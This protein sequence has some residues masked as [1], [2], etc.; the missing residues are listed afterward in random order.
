MS[1]ARTCISRL[2]FDD[3]GLATIRA[4]HRL[5]IVVIVRATDTTICIAIVLLHYV[6]VRVLELT[7]T[8]RADML[9]S[10]QWVWILNNSH[11]SFN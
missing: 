4:I 3:V 8:F 2:A 6:F 11:S 5:L 10:R 7:L 1:D 9:S